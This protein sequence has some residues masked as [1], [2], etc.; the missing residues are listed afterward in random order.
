MY[1]DWSITHWMLPHVSSAEGSWLTRVKGV[2]SLAFKDMSINTVNSENSVTWTL[3]F[4][5]ESV[6]RLS[7]VS[8]PVSL[9]VETHPSCIAQEPYSL[10]MLR[11]VSPSSVKGP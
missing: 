11:P 4:P 5:Q 8:S 1:L 3:S 9:V 10:T 7:S 2:Y 6:S